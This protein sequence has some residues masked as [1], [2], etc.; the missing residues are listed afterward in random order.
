MRTL[1]RL[2]PLLLSFLALTLVAFAACSPSGPQASGTAAEAVASGPQTSEGPAPAEPAADEPEL[3][4]EEEFAEHWSPWT[5]DLDGM[6]ER[7]VV[8]MLVTTNATNY[9]V[10]LGQQG[11]ATYEA[12][13]LLEKELNQRF[14]KGNLQLDVVFIP[15]TR[16]KLLPALVKGHGDIAAASLTITEGRLKTVDCSDPVTRE[17][18]EIVVT[19]P[20]A[21]TIASLEDLSGRRVYARKSSSFFESL[22]DLNADFAKKGLDPVE[23]IPADERLETEDILELTN[24]GVDPITVAD[25]FMVGRW[26]QVLKDMTPHPEVAVR[27]GQHFGWA[28]RKNS[29]QLKSLLNDFARKN[30]QGT[31]M[32]NIIMKRYFKNA[33]W[34]QNPGNE[35]D[36]ERFRSM[37]ALFRKYGEQYDLNYLLIT[38]QAYQ[39]SGLDQ[40]K[41]SGAGAIGVMQLLPS[42]ARDKNVGIPNIERLEDNIHAGV[43]YVRFILD[44]Y[45]K[46]APM[47]EVDK[48]L[49]AFASYNAGPGRITGLRKKAERMGLDPNKWRGNVE[50]VAAQEIGRETVQYVAN[51]FKYYMAYRLIEKRRLE[52][53]SAR[54]AGA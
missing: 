32:G 2:D 45:Y 22:Q 53:D 35:A 44:R 7:R 13:R 3:V 11:G 43:K 8:R 4:E 37:V 18:K 24:A 17:V 10:D 34:I 41:R 6:V 5:G 19:G 9:F 23:I 28:I 42:T 48:H 1:S 25:D 38:A 26:S 46:D 30:R 33:K 16:D 40:T 47:G 36:A 14:K 51:I 49:F 15:V 52:S 29:P 27:T 50:V 20:G 39:E 31:L 21:P 54:R 12:G